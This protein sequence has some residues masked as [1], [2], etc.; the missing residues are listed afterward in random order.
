MNYIKRKTKKILENKDNLDLKRQLT[1]YPYILKEYDIRFMDFDL[2]IEILDKKRV[3]GF[4]SLTK[5]NEH[6]Y[7][8]NDAYV[9]KE[10]RGKH[11]LLKEILKL[12][13]DNIE[14]SIK[15]P[16]HDFVEMLV[17][18]KF[19]KKLNENLVASALSFDI[20]D[21]NIL[22]SEE[23]EIEDLCSTFLYDLKLSS[24]VYIGDIV[25][26]NKCEIAYQK[27]LKSDERYSLE[28]RQNVHIKNYFNEFANNFKENIA[29]FG[30][31]LI[32]LKKNL[33]RKKESRIDRIIRTAIDN[34]QITP[35]ES[36]KYKK[37]L[38]EAQ[39][40]GDVLNEGL[41]RYFN[42]IINGEDNLIHPKE[43]SSTACPNCHRKINVK[44]KMCN[45]C[46]WNISNGNYLKKDELLDELIDEKMNRIIDEYFKSELNEEVRN[47]KDNLKT[48]IDDDKFETWTIPNTDLDYYEHKYYIK[49]DKYAL[50]KVEDE[51]KGANLTFLIHNILK[52]L[53]K[54]SNIYEVF[55]ELE[56]EDKSIIH[57]LVSTELIE[58]E[59]YENT[60]NVIYNRHSNEE[61]SEICKKHDLDG[62]GNKEEMIFELLNR[63]FYDEF[64]LTEFK[65]S[66]EGENLVRFT[67]WIDFYK[68]HM[69]IF[70]YDDFGNY[71]EK[72]NTHSF[73]PQCERYLDKHLKQAYDGKN[74]EKIHDII[75]SKSRFNVHFGNFVNALNDELQLFMI[76]I[77][78]VYL[79]DFD[80]YKFLLKSNINNIAVLS[81]ATN[82]KNLKKTFNKNWD[83]VKFNKK[84][85]SKKSALKYLNDAVN[86]KD[87]NI[88]ENAIKKKFLKSNY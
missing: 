51:N 59:D 57:E 83:K 29:E 5:Y 30:E 32:N 37:R 70:D 24:P 25:S 19:G 40:N 34:K 11:L 8:L 43:V 56:I 1:N 38:E 44:H 41:Q 65:L 82:K 47:L 15:E 69:K 23:F 20:E 74:F 85:I 68:D 73:E 60:G 63:G 81:Q 18:Y 77:N 80:D 12:L 10:F 84:F 88:I 52:A 71:I 28:F 49:N 35:E 4:L 7:A 78:P 53:E 31:V 33:P 27:L 79:D 45:H 9:L 72:I 13:L 17:H 16:T 86:G 42:Y 75:A 67:S 3:V 48:K 14:L 21:R 62:N 87:L 58:S 6:A 2:F 54:N 55:E 26:K 36:D 50:E 22:Y 76:S 64:G 66:N 39:S 46:G 61:L